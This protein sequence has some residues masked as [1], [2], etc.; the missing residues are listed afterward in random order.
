MLIRIYW[1]LCPVARFTNKFWKKSATNVS[2]HVNQNNNQV[3]KLF[4]IP[5]QPGMDI[6]N[7][8]S[9]VIE[10]LTIHFIIKK[11]QETHASVEKLGWGGVFSVDINLLWSIMQQWYSILYG[12]WWRN[13]GYVV[14][15]LGNLTNSFRTIVKKPV[16]YIQD[17]DSCLPSPNHKNLDQRNH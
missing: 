16:P 12:A 7:L 5:R 15:H 6:Y 8:M 1:L 11:N 4:G 9:N 14:I 17:G 10:R 2:E 3:Q 13:G